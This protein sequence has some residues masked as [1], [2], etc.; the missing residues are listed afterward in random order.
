MSVRDRVVSHLDR[1]V[2][3]I[4]NGTVVSPLGGTVEMVEIA[5]TGKD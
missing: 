1:T 2:D 3:I 4:L 5:L